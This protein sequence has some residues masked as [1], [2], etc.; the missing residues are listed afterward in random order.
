MTITVEATYENGI[1][2]PKQPLV[3]AEG[4][5]VRLTVTPMDENED[6]LAA[7]IGIG[8][9]RADGADQ[10]DKYIYGKLRP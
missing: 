6:P 2:K 5:A 9:G 7:V 10:H 3:L 4:T 8:E 1:L